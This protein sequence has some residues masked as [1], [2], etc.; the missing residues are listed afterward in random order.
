MNVS[1]FSDGKP[2]GILIS[3]PNFKNLPLTS[4]FVTISPN[5][6][7]MIV[8]VVNYHVPENV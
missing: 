1:I 4:H 2:D 6:V 8:F 5:I 3:S 7:F